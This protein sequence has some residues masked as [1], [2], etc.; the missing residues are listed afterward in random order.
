[1]WEISWVVDSYHPISIS[2]T[3]SYIL[4]RHPR[5]REKTPTRRSGYLHN[6][7][8]RDEMRHREVILRSVRPGT[9]TRTRF[10]HDGDT[11]S[12]SPNHILPMSIRSWC[13]TVNVWSLEWQAPVPGFLYAGCFPISLPWCKITSSLIRCSVSDTHFFKRKNRLIVHILTTKVLTQ[14]KT[15]SS[16]RRVLWTPIFLLW[17]G[18]GKRVESP[19][20]PLRAEVGPHLPRKRNFVYFHPEHATPENLSLRH[21]YPSLPMFKIVIYVHT[22]TYTY[23]F[24]IRIHPHLHFP[25]LSSI[26]LSRRYIYKVKTGNWN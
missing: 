19:V 10:N 12:V 2:P 7:A 14:L 6:L 9:K 23:T 25:F 5:S 15:R 21:T 26:H 24:Y 13:R 20:L 11:R 1:M 8:G 22:C 3:N 16:H 18:K 4:G 17:Q